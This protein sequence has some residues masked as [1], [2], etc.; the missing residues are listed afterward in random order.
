MSCFYHHRAR[1]SSFWDGG[2]PRSIVFQLSGAPLIVVLSAARLN[3]AFS[4]T[5]AGCRKG[6]VL[7]GSG[8]IVPWVVAPRSDRS[9]APRA[10]MARG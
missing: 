3:G 1:L 10:C 6:V 8:S 9:E 7:E 2:H 5:V 4:L